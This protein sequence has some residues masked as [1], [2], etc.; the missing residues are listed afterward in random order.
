MSVRESLSINLRMYRKEKGLSQAHLAELCD[1]SNGHIAE[2]ETGN[3][4]PGPETLEKIASALDVNAA[5]LLMSP[6]LLKD[7]SKY[8]ALKPMIEGIAN[9]VSRDVLQYVSEKLEKGT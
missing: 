6:E 9:Q 4:F 3:R 7:F 5:L 8:Q 1:L 2:I